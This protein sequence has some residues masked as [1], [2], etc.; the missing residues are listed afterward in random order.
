MLSVWD[1]RWFAYKAPAALVVEETTPT[2]D[3]VNFSKRAEPPKGKLPAPAAK[4]KPAA[5][6]NIQGI[7]IVHLRFQDVDGDDVPALLCRPA[8]TAGPLPV[9]I[10]LHGLM[11]SKIQVCAQV[12]PEL[13]RRGF[14]VLAPDMPLHGERPGNSGEFID[15]RDP[16]KA[17]A[18][19]RHTVIDLRQCI[20]LA[21]ARTDLDTSNG[22]ILMGYSMGSLVESVA[23]PCD[24]RVK[25]MCLMVGGTPEFPAALAGIP[26]FASIQPQLAIPHFAGRPLLMLNGRRDDIITSDM[27]ARLFSAAAEPK[28][29]VWYDS[30]HLLPETAYAEGAAWVQ[31]TWEAMKKAGK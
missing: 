22:V 10:A 25:A 19:Y 23:G 16:F 21:S 6:V 5:P 18:R 30:G 15:N 13:T 17:F 31:K 28:Q 2:A 14:A 3:Q 11:S 27:S 24:P 12:G 4:D 26:Q 8:N 9:V 29:Q 20:D 7:D 1:G